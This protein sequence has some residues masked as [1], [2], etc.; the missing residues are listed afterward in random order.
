TKTFPVFK[1]GDPHPFLYGKTVRHGADEIHGFCRLQ[2]SK[3]SHFPPVD[4]EHRDRAVQFTD[5]PQ[6]RAIPPDNNNRIGVHFCKGDT[7]EAEG[8]GRVLIEQGIAPAFRKRA[9]NLPGKYQRIRIVYP[10]NN[11]D[12][13]PVHLRYSITLWC[14]F[15]F[16]AT[17]HR[18]AV[19]SLGNR[20]ASPFRSVTLPP[21]S[22]QTS[23][24][25]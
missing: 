11:C 10:R 13:H 19:T 6:D 17:R 4:T 18:P 15:P 20:I 2:V 25:A 3:E 5:R 8:P 14:R 23:I 1:E 16:V 9:Q 7:F 21:A 24:P 12:L 22:L